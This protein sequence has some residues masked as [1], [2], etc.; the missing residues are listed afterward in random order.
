MVATMT[1][2]IGE[3]SVPFLSLDAEIPSFPTIFG[4]EPPPPRA[5]C[6]GDG[7]DLAGEDESGG[8]GGG[9]EGRCED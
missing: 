3:L 7:S 6:G 5:S 9:E 2:S 4:A 8:G 1:D